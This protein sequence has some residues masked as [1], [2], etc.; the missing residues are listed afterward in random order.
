MWDLLYYVIPQMII[1]S[2]YF[3]KCKR[4]RGLRQ[5]DWN[6]RNWKTRPGMIFSNIP[7]WIT[8]YDARQFSKKIRPC[9]N[10]GTLGYRRF[11]RNESFRMT[12]QN[13]D[14]KIFFKTDFFEGSILGIY[15]RYYIFMLTLKIASIF[16]ISQ[17]FMGSNYFL[18]KSCI[19]FLDER[20][21]F[22][23]KTRL[24]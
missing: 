5:N 2:E 16:E 20:H 24:L 12:P 1:F 19:W 9:E 18:D 22:S 17:V 7:L 14:S 8:V 11:N 10:V 13:I 23:R 4:W 6:V 3:A 15:F 21:L